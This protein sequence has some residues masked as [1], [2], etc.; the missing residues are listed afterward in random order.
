MINSYVD[1]ARTSSAR[2]DV[3]NIAAA[4]ISFNTDTRAWPIYVDSSDIPNGDVSDALETVGDTAALGSLTTGSSGSAWLGFVTN[5]NGNLQAVVNENSLALNTTGTRAWNGAYMNDI[6]TDPW[7]TKYYFNGSDLKP[8]GSAAA[9]VLS[10]GPDKT[11]DTEYTQAAS[12][13]FTVGNDDIV[14][15][16]R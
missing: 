4:I 7:G 15:R 10:A 5:S 12:G 9:F 6:D 3:R 2:N 16:I 13:T 11:I 1:R 14:Q 8:G